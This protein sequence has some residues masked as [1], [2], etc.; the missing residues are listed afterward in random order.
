LAALDIELENHASGQVDADLAY[1]VD[2]AKRIQAG[3]IVSSNDL[4]AK[5]ADALKRA[6]KLYPSIE[7][8]TTS[9]VGPPELE[10]LLS[11]IAAAAPPPDD[12]IPF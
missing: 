10:D 4:E 3:L 12:E 2:L 5:A 7:F 1:A 8:V 9:P 6:A 11:E